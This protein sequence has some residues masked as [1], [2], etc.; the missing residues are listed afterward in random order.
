MRWLD[1]QELPTMAPHPMTLGASDGAHDVYVE[2]ETNKNGHWAWA[3]NDPAR[4]GRILD[5]A[6]LYSEAGG[7]EKGRAAILSKYG[8]YSP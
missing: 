3:S 4:A 1:I 7:G 5:A 8:P 2:I 6:R